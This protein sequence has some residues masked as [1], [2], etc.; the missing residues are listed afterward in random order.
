MAAR[1]ANVLLYDAE[2]IAVRWRKEFGRN[3]AVIPYG[4]VSPEPLPVPTG[5]QHR[6]YALMVAR[7]V[8]ENTVPE[9][10]EAARDLSDVTDVVL[11]GS[12]GY[13]GELDEKASRLASDSRRIHWMGHLS[14][15]SLLFALWQHAGVYFHG[16]SVGGTNPALVQAMAC[17]APIVARDTVY[18]R[19]VL[20]DAGLFVGPAAHEIRDACMS[21]LGDVD[22]QGKLSNAA[23]VR[24][25]SHYAWPRVCEAYARLLHSAAGLSGGVGN[26]RS[27][28]G[29]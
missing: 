23:A 18:N 25:R 12:S 21:V 16:Q 10:L 20:E 3:G 4:G 22:L 28:P 8:P 13:G 11:V 14:D 2:A 6:K 26:G 27:I 9:F 19:E 17:G 15:D 7:F 5:L 29:P 24:A 1:C